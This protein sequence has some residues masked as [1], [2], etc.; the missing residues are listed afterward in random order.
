MKKI[1]FMLVFAL[2]LALIVPAAASE[3]EGGYDRSLAGTVINVYNWGQYISNGSDGTLDVN[4]EFTRRTGIIVNYSTYDSNETLYTKLKTGG[5]SYDVIIPSDYMVAKLIEENLLLPLNFDNI[6]NY[7]YIDEE[8]KNKSFDPGNAYSVPYTW[9]C[10]GV[11]YNTK[12]LTDPVT[13]WDALWNEKYSGK[14]LMFENSRDAFAVGALLLGLDVNSTDPADLDAIAEKLSEQRPLVQAYVMDQ[15]YEQMINEEAW[16]VSYYAGDF[17]QMQAENPSLAFCLPKEGFNLFIDSMC[18]PVSCANKAAAEAY[19]NFL[20]DPEIC[21]RNLEAIG[22]S[23]PNSAAKAYMSEETAQNAVAYP[24]SETLSRGVSF[25][26]LPND[27][28][29]YVNDLWLKVRTGG[30]STSWVIYAA[31]AAAVAGVG[32]FFAIRRKKR[33]N[34]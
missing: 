20:C 6:P 23:A 10:T 8:F 16:L 13:G 17:L 27:T 18:I 15:C 33:N 7:R 24:D 2:T 26:N 25:E 11:I 3:T 21:G 4:A 29:R 34:Y 28:I 19:I 22:Y 30:R 1:A 32:I 12:Y 14:I 31:A 5:A 9:G